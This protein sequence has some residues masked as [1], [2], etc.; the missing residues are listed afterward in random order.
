MQSLL[1]DKDAGGDGVVNE[2]LKM[3]PI[4]AA[5]K[6]IVFFKQRY[7]GDFDHAVESWLELTLL[8]IRKCAKPNRFQTSEGSASAV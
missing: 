8:W 6:I 3:I 2:V 1:F 7:R 4:V 5:H